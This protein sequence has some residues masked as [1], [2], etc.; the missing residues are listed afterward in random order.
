MKIVLADERCLPSKC[1]VYCVIFV[2]VLFTADGLSKLA[3][4]VTIDEAQNTVQSNGSGAVAAPAAPQP[5]LQPDTANDTT[6]HSGRFSVSPAP[7][8]LD[9]GSCNSA[10][11]IFCSVVT[12]PSH[13]IQVSSIKLCLF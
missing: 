4:K 8:L 7:P 3:K 13:P 5:R 1:W 6:E 10:W 11:S 2:T 9:E 12:T